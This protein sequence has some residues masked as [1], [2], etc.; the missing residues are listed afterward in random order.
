MSLGS[1][2]SVRESALGLA[3]HFPR[4]RRRT[5]ISSMSDLQCLLYMSTA[6]RE[7]APGEIDGMLQ[8]ARARNESLGITG[9]LLH[10]GGRF[11][12]VLEGEPAAVERC[13]ERISADNRHGDI[14]RIYSGP[15]AAP[16]FPDWSMRYV[17]NAGPPDRAV[18]A[19]L[20]ELQHRPSP[21]TVRQ[22][23]AL[24]GRLAGGSADWQSR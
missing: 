19:F 14:Q 9:A 4:H 7:M 15:V 18:V 20:D 16:S 6:S 13:F 12:Q 3:F 17:V 23:I 2:P 11:V 24:L 21:E 22:A 10:Y 1:N 5:Y 8:R